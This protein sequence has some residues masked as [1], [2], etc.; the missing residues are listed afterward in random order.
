MTTLEG[1]ETSYKEQTGA[2]IDYKH[3]AYACFQNNGK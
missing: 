1:T 3:E 2:R